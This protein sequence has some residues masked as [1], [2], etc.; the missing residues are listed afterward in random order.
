M[1]IKEMLEAKLRDFDKNS[2]PKRKNQVINIF[3]KRFYISPEQIYIKNYIRKTPIAAFNP[4]A[5]VIDKRVYIFPRMIFDY[6]TYNSSIG[7]F[8]IGID[9]LMDGAIPEKLDT[10]ILLWPD[11]MWEFGH[12]VEDPRI[13]KQGDIIYML[14]TGSK[15]Y[16]RDSRLNKKSVLALSE[17]RE[18]HKG[19]Y[20]DKKGYFKIIDSDQEYVPDCKDSAFI[21]PYNE[22]ITMLLRFDTDSPTSCWRG[23]SNIDN[24]TIDVNSIEP[25]FVPCEWEEKVGWS[26]NVVKVA[27]DKYLVGW[28]GVL[29]EDLSYKDGFALVD[30]K[31]KLLGITNYLLSPEGL[32]E[33]YGDRGLVIFGDGLLRYDDYI[34][35]IGG[36]SDYAIGV[37]IVS[38]SDILDQML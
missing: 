37:F 31:G 25:V 33:S 1:K 27:E 17:I 7:V 4:G 9:E 14:Y 5:I 32:I 3:K 19:L 26:T 36:I 16:E 28:H 10:E 15:H 21:K 22:E 34:I 23:M 2:V 12:G 35:W 6:Y 8:S 29:K 18:R 11:K 30:G 13:Y 38:L 20:A 24:L